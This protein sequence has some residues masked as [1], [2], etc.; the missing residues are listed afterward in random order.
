MQ[1][2]QHINT[3]LKKE[4]TLSPHMQTHYQYG[5]DSLLYIV[6]YTHPDI[7]NE[8]RELSKGM[9]SVNK[10]NY[11]MLLLTLKYLESTK[12]F[13]WKLPMTKIIHVTYRHTTMMIGK[14]M[15]RIENM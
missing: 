3:S 14:V 4:D 8:T 5:V 15:K 11:I 2:H 7:S 10:H 12:H 1:C 6:K 13:I 9:V